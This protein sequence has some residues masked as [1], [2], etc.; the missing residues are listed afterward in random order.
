MW[1]GHWFMCEDFVTIPKSVGGTE[2]SLHDKHFVCQT[3]AMFFAPGILVTT[4]STFRCQLVLVERSVD[5]GAI[6]SREHV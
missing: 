5:Q 2:T 4:E 1:L 3:T 6:K